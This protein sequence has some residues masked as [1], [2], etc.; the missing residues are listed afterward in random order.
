MIEMLRRLRIN[1]H[2]SRWN[3]PKNWIP[4]THLMDCDKS[5]GSSTMRG[6]NELLHEESWSLVRTYIFLWEFIIQILSSQLSVLMNCS[7][8]IDLG[9]F[10]ATLRRQNKWLC[11]KSF[12]LCF[13][14]LVSQ[15]LLV[16]LH[17]CTQTTCTRMTTLLILYE[18][19]ILCYL[20]FKHLENNKCFNMALMFLSALS[21]Q[22]RWVNRQLMQTSES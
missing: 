4:A 5:Y 7:C 6:W 15:W 14:H 17:H 12:T 22:M 19:Q 3:A 2:T 1:G 11:L 8:R 16:R 10:A 18:L 21:F 13:L 9:K 20:W